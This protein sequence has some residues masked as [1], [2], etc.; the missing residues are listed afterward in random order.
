MGKRKKWI[1]TSI[2][3]R[4]KTCPKRVLL[5]ECVISVS[6]LGTRGNFYFAFNENAPTPRW[7]LFIFIRVSSSHSIFCV[8]ARPKKKKTKRALVGY[9]RNAEYSVSRVAAS[10]C[11]I[12]LETSSRALERVL[13]TPFEYMRIVH[14]RKNVI[15]HDD[16]VHPHVSPHIAAHRTIRMNIL[17][18]HSRSY[19]ALTSVLQ[20]RCRCTSSLL[21]LLAQVFEMFATENGRIMGR[22]SCRSTTLNLTLHVE[23]G[24]HNP[25]R[26]FCR[27]N[28]F[29]LI[30]S[31][32]RA[33]DRIPRRY[34]CTHIE[35]IKV[36][37]TANTWLSR[38]DICPI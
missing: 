20:F 31:R 25:S 11:I 8:S 36:T 16:P 17:V 1:F 29:N 33:V 18:T 24:Y 19:I 32:W 23:T 38:G 9:S 3:S 6:I 34:E 21:I 10:E 35:R 26:L 12:V 37:R 14:P 28:V 15:F 5:H 13:A 7:E 22:L 30:S 27:G 2:A 4:R